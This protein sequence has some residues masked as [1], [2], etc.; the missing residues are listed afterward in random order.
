M[1]TKQKNTKTNVPT[2]PEIP[3][4]VSPA[5]KLWLQSTKEALEVRLGRRGDPRDR[6]ITLRELI[7]SGLAKELRANPY[8]P[9][10]DIDFVPWYEDPADL[11]IL[12]YT[13]IQVTL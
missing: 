5:V 3:S 4:D 12:K 10:T 8:D 7:E 1:A 13:D 2:I 6:A 11:D 9:N